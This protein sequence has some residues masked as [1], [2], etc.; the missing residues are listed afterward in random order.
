VGQPVVLRAVTHAPTSRSDTAP[1]LQLSPCLV[2]T[3]TTGSWC[4]G[5]ARTGVIQRAPHGLHPRP[6]GR[7][8]AL[9]WSGVARPLHNLQ[10]PLVKGLGAVL[11][12]AVLALVRDIP[13]GDQFLVSV[14][15]LIASSPTCQLEDHRT[16]ELLYAVGSDHV[17]Q[18]FFKQHLRQDGG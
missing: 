4:V 15:Q 8:E 11:G 9:G 17:L 2:C 5:A 13:L 7:G 14:R 10:H 12:A 3:S 16:E 18:V 1:M 6:L